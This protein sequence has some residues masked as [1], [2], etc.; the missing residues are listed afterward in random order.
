MGVKTVAYIKCPWCGETAAVQQGPKAPFARCG[1]GH[2]MASVKGTAPEVVIVGLQQSG[3]LV[4]LEQV[5]EEGEDN[6]LDGD[7]AGDN[8]P[9]DES[10]RVEGGHGD[11]DRG[12]GSE[13]TGL[14][15]I[16]HELGAKPG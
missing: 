8:G 4:R 16:R 6:G 2:Y 10:G 14:D 9:G 11:A 5:Q 7:R 15:A 3:A 13:L 12:D 1:N